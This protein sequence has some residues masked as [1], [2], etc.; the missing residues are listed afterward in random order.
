MISLS[1][2]AMILRWT[3]VFVIFENI[4]NDQLV[5]PCGGFFIAIVVFVIFEIVFN[6]QSACRSLQMILCWTIVFVIFENVFND[7]LVVP[8]G[9]FFVATVVFV[10]SEIVFNNQLVV[11]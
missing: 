8:C 9:G 10:I 7:Q 3:I 1:F 11:P 5:V 2:L 6:D 4:F